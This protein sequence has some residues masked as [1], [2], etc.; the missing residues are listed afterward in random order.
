MGHSLCRSLICLRYWSFSWFKVLTSLSSFSIIWKM[1][2]F[3]SV[4]SS[5][6]YKFFCS[7]LLLLLVCQSVLK[8]TIR[9]VVSLSFRDA[10]TH[11]HTYAHKERE[12]EED[13]GWGGERKKRDRQA[14]TLTD[15][16]RQTKKQRC[17]REICLYQILR[18]DLCLQFPH[19]TAV[20]NGQSCCWQ[21]TWLWQ[22]RLAPS[23]LASYG[24]NVVIVVHKWCWCRCL[25]R[26]S[27]RRTWVFKKMQ[28][29]LKMNK[30]YATYTAYI[31][32]WITHAKPSK[33]F[34]WFSIHSYVTNN[35]LFY[36]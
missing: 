8:M 1:Y 36:V 4:S 21:W 11:T 22:Q 32:L 18:V 15:T 9:N 28:L 31:T 14:G 5:H 24:V 19:L 26:V 25:K 20:C 23:H 6:Y 30:W 27:W 16:D 29:K 17:N 10:H 2:K 33:A 35:L 13:E 7:M 34:M 3:C 12:N